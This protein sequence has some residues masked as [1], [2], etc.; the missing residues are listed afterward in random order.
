MKRFFTVAITLLL[1]VGSFAG[2]GRWG[3]V[4]GLTS[5]ASNLDAAFSDLQ[6]KNV[7][8]Y[9]AGVAYNRK[10]F[11][12]FRIQPEILYNVKGAS[13]KD[14]RRFSDLDLRTGF[15]EVPV[16]IQWC[17]VNLFE[18][19]K[20]YVFAEPFVGYAVTNRE[21]ED[22]YV[23][24]SWDSVK[25]RFEYGLGLGFGADLL[26][27]LQLSVK[28]YWNVGSLYDFSLADTKAALAQPCNG[29]SASLALFF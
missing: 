20:A 15:V 16:Q 11:A 5:T 28:Y 27:H 18:V 23:S 8:L 14:I 29:I 26:K 4:G 13:V 3:V 10:L 19:F 2:N 9:H 22:N 21:I 1:T 24:Q 6:S 25:S 7:S 17:P 12:G